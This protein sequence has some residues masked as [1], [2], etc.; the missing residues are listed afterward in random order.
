MEELLNDTQRDGTEHFVVMPTVLEQAPTW[1]ELQNVFIIF[2]SLK[3]GD[4]CMKSSL[5]DRIFSTQFRVYNQRYQK[6]KWFSLSKFFNIRNE[7]HHEHWKSY[8]RQPNAAVKK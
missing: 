7:Q 8:K 2:L 4:S 6:I 5:I 1:D 3:S